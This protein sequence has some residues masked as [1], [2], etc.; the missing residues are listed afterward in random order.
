MRG[1]ESSLV[2]EWSCN[3][4]PR[5]R[6]EVSIVG[7]RRAET[8]ELRTRAEEQGIHI[9]SSS[10]D[11]KYEKQGEEYHQRPRKSASFVQR[12]ISTLSSLPLQAIKRHSG[13]CG[14]RIPVGRSSV[15]LLELHCFAF[16]EQKQK[17]I[18]L[19]SKSFSWHEDEQ[20]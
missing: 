2:G 15:E 9:S 3:M 13:I 10:D 8:I 4:V 19:L 1:E 6:F 17:R 18:T 7:W 5:N 16:T 12:Q 11:N 14:H 20:T